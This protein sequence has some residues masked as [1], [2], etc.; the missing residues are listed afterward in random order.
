MSTPR[1]TEPRWGTARTSDWRRPSTRSP[2]SGTRDHDLTRR[3]WSTTISASTSAY[4]PS[5]SGS[6]W[7]TELRTFLF[8]FDPGA[9]LEDEVVEGAAV[10]PRVQEPQRRAGPG[11]P[12]AEP[13][14]LT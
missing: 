8:L 12:Q 2:A 7:A 5:R 11:L 14:H 10:A 3:R 1:T 13:H 4:S 6:P 9:P